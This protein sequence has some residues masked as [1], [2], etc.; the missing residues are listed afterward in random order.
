MFTALNGAAQRLREL[1]AR[2]PSQCAACHAWPAQR[3][4]ADCVAR[5][6]PPATR[7]RRCALRVPDAVA[8]CGACL[9]RAPA[10]DA[11]LAAVDYAYPWDQA[12]AEFKFGGD[13]GWAAALAGVLQRAPQVGAVLAAADRVLPMPLSAQRLCARGFNQSLLLARCLARAKT[14]AHS[15]LRLHASEAQSR[16]AR[17]QRLRNLR[18]AFA[19]AADRAGALRGRRLVLV[20][21]V[22]TTGASAHAATLAL[23]AAGAAQVTVLV[24]ARTAVR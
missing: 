24:L 12:L 15:L 4:C 1:A 10:F 14:D 22:M 20:D 6:A 16:L 5:F 17:A 23:R 7:C 3:I 9:I 21:D 19:V 8:V 13:P 2:I 18:G 11:C